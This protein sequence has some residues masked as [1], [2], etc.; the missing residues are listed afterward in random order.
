VLITRPEPAANETARIVAERGY[1]PVLAPMLT[2]AAHRL[3]R[4]KATHQ[5]ILVTSANALPALDNFDRG[6]PVMAVGDAT[7][8]RAGKAGFTRVASAG[9]DA[10][11]LAGLVEQMC[12]P[13]GGPLYLA[14]GA[15][16]GAT[17]ASALRQSGFTVRRVVAYGAKPVR[18][19]P[20]A[21]IDAIDG[22]TLRHAMFFSSATATAFVACIMGRA[23]R[24][25]GVEA[26]AISP[27]TARA[28]APLPWLRIRV[29]S[30]PNQDELVALL[31]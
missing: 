23:G 24:L 2:I 18:Q 7:A 19:L 28:L 5:A 8:A 17:L 15:G 12:T 3:P 13:D 25:E 30:H 14:S 22:T 29:A 11:A 4:P 27:S 26:L 6:I 10:V 16:Q 20:Q 1:N 21:A 9:R 31:T